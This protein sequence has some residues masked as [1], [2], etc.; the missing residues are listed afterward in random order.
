MKTTVLYSI[1]G[2]YFIQVFVK[3]NLFANNCKYF[4]SKDSIV[5]QENIFI[6]GIIVS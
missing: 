4:Y 5:N 6:S 1:D 2:I 3:A